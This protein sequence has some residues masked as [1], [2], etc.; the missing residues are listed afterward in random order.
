[1]TKKQLESEIL[2]IEPSTNS[3]RSKQIWQW[4]YKHKIDDLNKITVLSKDFK[5][6][7]SKNFH[8]SFGEVENV[9]KSSVDGTQKFLVNWNGNKVESK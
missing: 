1:M 2:K 8:I 3:Y 4:I 7:L 6:K 9:E 5:D